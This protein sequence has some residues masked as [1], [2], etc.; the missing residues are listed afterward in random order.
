MSDWALAALAVM[1][2]MKFVIDFDMLKSALS[3]KLSGNALQKSLA[4]VE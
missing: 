1:A 4:V 3:V 2:K